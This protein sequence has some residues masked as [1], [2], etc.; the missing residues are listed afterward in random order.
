MD[1]DV[2]SEKD[3]GRILRLIAGGHCF[4]DMKVLQMAIDKKGAV[5][6]DFFYDNGG[7]YET[8]GSGWRPKSE[9]RSIREVMISAITEKIEAENRKPHKEKMDADHYARYL[10]ALAILNVPKDHF[11]KTK[12]DFMRN[13]FLE[14]WK[15]DDGSEENWKIIKEAAWYIAEA[16]KCI[17]GGPIRETILPDE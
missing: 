7:C 11:N 6:Q 4:D 2:I 3:L 15:F 12:H 1:K 8:W 14:L 5:S 9:L 17:K 10:H 13:A 16:V